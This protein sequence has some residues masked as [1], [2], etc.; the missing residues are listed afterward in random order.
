MIGN[1]YLN[2][3]NEEESFKF[4]FNFYRHRLSDVVT[5]HDWFEYMNNYY[6]SFGEFISNAFVFTITPEGHDYWNFIRNSA[7]D[8]ITYDPK[9]N[10][11]FDL[12]KEVF[13]DEPKSVK[14]K[15]KGREDLNDVLK[16]LNITKQ[17]N[18]MNKLN[19]DINPFLCTIDV[20]AKIN[21]VEERCNTFYNP[22][23]FPEKVYAM[24]GDRVF[25]ILIDYTDCLNIVVKDDDDD[26]EQQYKV[27]IIK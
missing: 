9:H 23:D 7:R 24:L 19:L 2:M 14:R 8:G 10:A 4:K 12:L 16:E 11:F 22:H 13:A 6:E 1:Q 20:S 18:K 27:R 26:T 5:D 21:G 15:P 17:K 3:L 25:S